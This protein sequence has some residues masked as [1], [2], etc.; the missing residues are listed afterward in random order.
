MDDARVPLTYVNV[1]P[2]VV[3]LANVCNRVDGVEGAQD[4]RATSAVDKVRPISTLNRL[5]DK[6]LQFSGNHLASLQRNK[7]HIIITDKE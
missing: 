4:G 1:Q 2:E 7:R 6:A 3:L 5:T